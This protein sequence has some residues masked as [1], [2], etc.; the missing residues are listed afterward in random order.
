MQQKIYV[1]LQYI[2]SREATLQYKV[3][4]FI[5]RAGDVELR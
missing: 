3:L 4:Y 1:H 5:I 2:E